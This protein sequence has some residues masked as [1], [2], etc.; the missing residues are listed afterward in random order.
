[1][2]RLARHIRGD[3]RKLAF[4]FL[5]SMPGAP[6]IYY[7][8]EIGMNYV[9]GLDSVEG[10]Y[11]RTGS[12]SPMQWDGS[13]N[14]GFSD[15]PAH[16]L[17]IPIDPDPDRPTVQKQMSSPDSLRSEVRKLIEIRQAH[18][19]LQSL[20]GIEF[21][22]DGAKGRPL[23]YIRSFGDESIL[24]AV[25]P[26]DTPCALTVDGTPGEVFYSF[27]KGAEFS[28]SRCVIGA[29]SSVFAEIKR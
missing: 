13:K 19:A 27:G 7:G 10:G 21:I 17:Y 18:K 29:G 15:A 1:M 25:N 2:D 26:T 8:D 3:N 24:A 22:C 5:L 12:R 20:G 14:A 6:Y 23:A 16:K 28:G 9:E 4:A 11:G